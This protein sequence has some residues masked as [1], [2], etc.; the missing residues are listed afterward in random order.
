MSIF[1]FRIINKYKNKINFIITVNNHQ[2]FYGFLSH[3]N[4]IKLNYPNYNY[5][6]NFTKNIILN[7][8]ININL[9]LIDKIIIIK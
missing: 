9:N 3:L 2:K 7:E 1:I 6:Y 4:I 8:N 5:L